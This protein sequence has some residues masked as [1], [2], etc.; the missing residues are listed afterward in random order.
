MF[1]LIVHIDIEKERKRDREKDICNTTMPVMRLLQCKT[2][3]CTW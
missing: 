3:H 1:N 2:D